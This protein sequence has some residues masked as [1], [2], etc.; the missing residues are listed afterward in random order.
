MNRM[1]KGIEQEKRNEFKDTTVPHGK[2]YTRIALWKNTR[3][4]VELIIFGWL[5][6]Y[7]II[8]NVGCYAI[9]HRSETES[10]LMSV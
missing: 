10:D 7:A 6:L 9:T 4:N 2:K 8:Q 3:I 5:F 1:Q